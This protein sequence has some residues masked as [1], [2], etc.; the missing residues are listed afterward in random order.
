MVALSRGEVLGLRGKTKPPQQKN[1]KKAS[2]NDYLEAYP[3]TVAALSRGEV[4]GLRAKQKPKCDATVK[5]RKL[6]N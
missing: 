3:F 6:E 5:N 1:K 4:L 2:H